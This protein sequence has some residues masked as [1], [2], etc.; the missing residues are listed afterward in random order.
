M[1][2]IVGVLLFLLLAELACAQGVYRCKG[3]RGEIAFT[4]HPHK[5]RDCRAVAVEVSPPAVRPEVSEA[6]KPRQAVAAGAASEHPGAKAPTQRGAI[7][8]FRRNGITHYTNIRPK[9]GGYEIVLTY[10]QRCYACALRSAIDWS[11]VPLDRDAFAEE[12]AAAAARHGV[13][14]ALI[15]AVMHAE[16]N[17][18]A[19]ARS[20]KGAQG[21]MQ[22]MP[23]TA[24]ELGVEDPYDP[25]QNIDGGAAYLA[26]ML[27]RFGDERLALAAYNAG[28]EAVERHGGIPPFAETRV[29][30]ER[31]SQLRRR[32]ANGE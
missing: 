23:G 4:S 30:V 32:Y 16:S 28:P 7:Y 31:V 20:H 22:L 17:F 21:L 26:K 27:E 25:R 9:H 1:R 29:Y 13:E 11:T 18:R 3:P 2:G 10:I 14:E 6:A 5:F 12:V 24:R 15:R 19:G 8:K